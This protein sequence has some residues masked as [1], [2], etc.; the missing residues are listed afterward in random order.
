M[1]FSMLETL[2]SVDKALLE[3]ACAAFKALA[4]SESS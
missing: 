2:L 1:L 3:A 4:A